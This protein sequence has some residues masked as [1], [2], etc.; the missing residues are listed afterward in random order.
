MSGFYDSGYFQAS[1]VEFLAWLRRYVRRAGDF[2]AE[3]GP[4][5]HW[6][7]VSEVKRGPAL[8][9]VRRVE[10]WRCHTGKLAGDV[11]TLSPGWPGIVGSVE[12][13]SASRLRVRLELVEERLAGVWDALI[14][15]FGAAWPD[16]L[17]QGE[18]VTAAPASV[19]AVADGERVDLGRRRVQKHRVERWEK[20]RLNYYPQGWTQAKIAEAEDLSVETIK[21]DYRLMRE[22]G[23]L[24]PK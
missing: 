13:L 3:L 16:A 10:I 11:E 18:T 9:G 7:A 15:E 2:S 6:Y 21:V 8:D 12:E 5:R 4:G 14:C 24:P 17:P 23:L 22:R 20:I 19:A 1:G